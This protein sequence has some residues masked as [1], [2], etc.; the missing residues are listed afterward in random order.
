MFR[1][2]FT[3]LSLTICIADSFTPPQSCNQDNT[4]ITLGIWLALTSITCIFA[5]QKIKPVENNPAEDNDPILVEDQT[6]PV[7][8][9]VPNFPNYAIDPI[10]FGGTGLPCLSLKMLTALGL[11]VGVGVGGFVVSSGLFHYLEP[12]NDYIDETLNTMTM[13]N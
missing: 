2:I 3:S 13:G 7:G 10:V 8:W 12:A 5:A 1:Y 11:I 9:K 6:S 4:N